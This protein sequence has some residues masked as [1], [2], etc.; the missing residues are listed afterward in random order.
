MLYPLSQHH[1]VLH[2]AAD[3]HMCQLDN[4]IVD[5]FKEIVLKE[6]PRE[7]E[8]FVARVAQEGGHPNSLETQDLGTVASSSSTLP[9]LT[10][11]ALSLREMRQQMIERGL[12]EPQKPSLTKRGREKA[13]LCHY[14]MTTFLKFLLHTGGFAAKESHLSAFAPWTVGWPEVSRGFQAF[15]SVTVL[16]QGHYT[17][18]TF[19]KFLLH[20]GGFAAKESHLS[21]FAAASSRLPNLLQLLEK[22]PEEVWVKKERTPEQA[23]QDL[24]AVSDVEHTANALHLLVRT[25]GFRIGRIWRVLE[26]DL[27]VQP[28]SVSTTEV[29]ALAKEMANGLR[30]GQWP[31]GDAELGAVGI[32]KLWQHFLMEVKQHC[33]PSSRAAAADSRQGS[34]DEAPDEEEA[35]QPTLA[36][37]VSFRS[38][39]A[40]DEIVGK[41]EPLS[42]SEIRSLQD[43]FSVVHSLQSHAAMAAFLKRILL[44]ERGE[45]NDQAGFAEFVQSCVDD[46][47]SFTSLQQEC[48]A[49]GV[50]SVRDQLLSQG[51]DKGS[52]VHFDCWDIDLQ[53][54]GAQICVVFQTAAHSLGCDHVTGSDEEIFAVTVD[55]IQLRKKSAERK[56][57][58]IVH[59]FQK[60]V[61]S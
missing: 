61:G 21:A 59:H 24:L 15:F 32:G 3:G 54:A 4:L 56:T 17:M 28:K 37:A 55:H 14:T 42:K 10:M 34:E 50:F 43:G 36:T 33:L 12:V 25:R 31:Q 60:L 30:N 46:P 16:D 52:S 39:G 57:K 41:T 9:E 2:W 35:E 26:E 22:L 20:T 38:D 6:D 11:G 5:G 44:D 53:L 18:T 48:Q 23:F 47:P 58:F 1:V 49:H 19:L 40:L 13:M 45:V 51:T 7:M 29:H 8:H 27:A